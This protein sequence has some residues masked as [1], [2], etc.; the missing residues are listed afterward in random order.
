MHIVAGSME[1]FM[2][3][4]EGSASVIQVGAGFVAPMLIGNQIG[5]TVLFALLTYAQ[6]MKEMA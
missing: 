1:A 5:G 3:M 6:V 4:W 2:L